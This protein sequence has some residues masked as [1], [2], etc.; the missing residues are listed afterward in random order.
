MIRRPPRSTLFPYTTLFRSQA[1]VVA[2]LLVQQRRDLGGSGVA[3]DDAGG[4]GVL[5]RH[6]GSPP[7]FEGACCGTS[8]SRPTPPERSLFP[9][10]G[11]ECRADRDRPR[12]HVDSRPDRKSVV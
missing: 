9:L 7:T 3:E 4:R 11:V 5:H 10:Y 6:V 12:S 8:C 1:E 2:T